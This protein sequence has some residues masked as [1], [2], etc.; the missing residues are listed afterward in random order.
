MAAAK[1]EILITRLAYE[2]VTKFQQLTPSSRFS[3]HHLGFYGHLAA[4]SIHKSTVEILD[5]ENMG[6]AVGIFLLS[7]VFVYT[8]ILFYDKHIANAYKTSNL[9][10]TSKVWT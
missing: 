3:G 9:R 6:V 2:I 4:D 10:Y 8:Y 1:P 5:L 7:C